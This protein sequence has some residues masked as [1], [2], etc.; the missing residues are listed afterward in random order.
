MALIANQ[1]KE[2]LKHMTTINIIHDIKSDYFLEELFVNLQNKKLLEIIK[3]NKAIK[4]RLHININDYKECSKIEIELKFANNK[5]NQFIN[6]PDKDKEYYH[7]YF[8]NSKE[9]IKRNYLN[10]NEKVNIIKIIIDH[11]ITSFQK[12]FLLMDYHRTYSSYQLHY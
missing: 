10:E 4:K 8:D 3:Y 12:L 1:E 2:I 5:Y 11:Q 6:L 9:E 7:I